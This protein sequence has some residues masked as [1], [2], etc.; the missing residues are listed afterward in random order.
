VNRYNYIAELE[1][2]QTCPL[3]PNSGTYTSKSFQVIGDWETT[4]YTVET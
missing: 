2:L 4:S 3:E 1:S